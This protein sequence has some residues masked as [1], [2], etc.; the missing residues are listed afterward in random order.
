MLSLFSSQRDVS[1]SSVASPF[2]A[3]LPSTYLMRGHTL[4]HPSLLQP[5]ASVKAAVGRITEAHRSPACLDTTPKEGAIHICSEGLLFNSHHGWREREKTTKKT[6]LFC[7]LLFA[8]LL[9]LTCRRSALFHLQGSSCNSFLEAAE[10][11]S[12]WR[13]KVTAGNKP[14]PFGCSL[15]SAWAR[16][17]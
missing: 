10:A 14:K 5:V 2:S 15:F 6:N 3:S 11:L 1:S 7:Q 4:L 17:A 12:Q 8:L 13:G 9:F 16:L